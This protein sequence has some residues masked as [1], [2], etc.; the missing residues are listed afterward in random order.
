MKSLSIKSALGAGW[1][2][3]MER[4]WYLFGVTLAVF[5]L[6]ALTIGNAAATALSY[7]VFGGYLDLLIRH[8]KHERVEFDDLFPVD[9]RW[10]HF[11]FLSIIKWFA[12]IIG[13]VLFIVPGMYLAVRWS[14][15]EYYVI[16]EKMRPLEALR[17]SSALTSGYRWKI[18]GYTVLTTILFI[19]SLLLLVVGIAAATAIL[20][21]AT[22]KLFEDLKALKAAQLQTGETEAPI[23]PSVET[24]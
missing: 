17:A 3:F 8:Y 9:M 12:I 7:I 1:K 20:V 23:L 10:V 2:S 18:F 14:F 5:L 15:A 6:F 19:A 24:V 13:L 4:P 21:I 22:Y 16:T 11:A